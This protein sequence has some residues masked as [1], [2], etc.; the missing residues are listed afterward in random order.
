MAAEIPTSSALPSD[1]LARVAARFESIVLRR[2]LIVGG[3]IVL[4]MIGLFLSNL[5]VQKAHWYW[6]AMFPVFGIVCV[7][8]ELAGGAAQE[9]P[10][11]KVLLRQAAH[12][13][14]PIVALRILFLQHERGQ[15]SADAVALVVLLVL[16]VTCFL[17]G[18]HFD[19]SFIWVSLVLVAAAIL[20]TEIETY[21]WLVALLGFVALALAIVSSAMLRRHRSAPAPSG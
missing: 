7:W 11:W 3:L 20:G 4:V 16:A 12:W 14:F 2:A 19:Q 8:H 17:A 18:V 1:R 21:I 6:A 5:A 9:I 10:L 13:L 15:M